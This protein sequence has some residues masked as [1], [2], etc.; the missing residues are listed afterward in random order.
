MEK[1]VFEVSVVVEIFGEGGGEGEE[2]FVALEGVEFYAIELEGD[3]VLGVE[4]WLRGVGNEV[5]ERI[6][7]IRV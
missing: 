1:S 5:S 6:D 3:V 2:V 4:G 7:F